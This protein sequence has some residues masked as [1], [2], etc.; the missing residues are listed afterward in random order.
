MLNDDIYGNL[1]SLQIFGTK[2]EQHIDLF[3]IHKGQSPFRA[4]AFLSMQRLGCVVWVQCLPGITSGREAWGQQS[5]MPPV[6]LAFLKLTV[7][8]NI[9][10]VLASLPESNRRAGDNPCP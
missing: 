9:F 7:H 8:F 10:R 5:D 6:V 1:M 3:R 2:Y 4:R